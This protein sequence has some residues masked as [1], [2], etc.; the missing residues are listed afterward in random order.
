MWSV[1]GIY[2]TFPDPFDSLIEYFTVNGMPTAASR[3]VDHAIDWLV[4]LHFGR[5]FGPYVKALWA[6]L[7]LV[8]GALFVTGALMWWNRVLRRAIGAYGE[9]IALPEPLSIERLPGPADCNADRASAA[10]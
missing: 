3:F 6:I 8:P 4:R 5:S 9:P 2:L 10:R 1:T 7:G